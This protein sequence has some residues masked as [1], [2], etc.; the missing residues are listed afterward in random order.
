MESA[1][2]S[3]WRTVPSTTGTQRRLLMAHSGLQLGID[4]VG[5]GGIGSEFERQVDI[6]ITPSETRLCHADNRVVLVNQLNGLPNHI[7]IAVVMAL[8]ELVT[9]HDYGLRILTFRSVRRDQAPPYQGWHAEVIEAVPGEINCVHIFRKVA[10]GGGKVPA[11]FSDGAFH[12]LRLSILLVLGAGRTEPAVFAG[13]VLGH[14]VNHAIGVRIR[15]GIQQNRVDD[16]EYGC[17]GA[18]AERQ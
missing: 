14:Q 10:A 4:L 18:N 13:F 3:P 9:E 11:I 15:V 5:P 12:R 8:P 2:A 17:G 16:A 6:T 1:M 7:G